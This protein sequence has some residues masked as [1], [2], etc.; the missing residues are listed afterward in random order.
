[1]SVFIQAIG[2]GLVTASVIAIASVGFTLQFGVTNILNLAYGDTM[3]AAAFVGY[4]VNRSGAALIYSF[5]AAAGFGAVFSL[6]L[7]RW[8]YSRF[9]VHGTSFGGMIIV[10]LLTG[11]VIQHLLLA[12]FGSNFDVYNVGQSSVTHL[13]DVTLSGRQFEIIAVAVICMLAVQ[14]IL[15]STK[16]GKAMRATASNAGL[17]RA[18]GIRVA[19]VIDVAW[20]ISGSLCGMAGVV[21]VLNTTSFDATTGAAFLIVVVSSAMLGGVGNA[22]GAMAASVLVGIVTSVTAAYTNPSYQ[23]VFAFVMLI[24]VL[25]VRPAGLLGVA[26]SQVQAGG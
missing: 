5:L 24:I 1:M 12:G 18:S 4:I 21:L 11:G 16:L 25:I 9:T 8:F 26:R 15:R 3:T 6:V 13:G 17:A 23:Y 14:F 19:R 20:L 2:F 7:N 22:T 10:T